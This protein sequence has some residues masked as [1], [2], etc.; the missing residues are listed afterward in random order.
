VYIHVPF[1]RRRCDYCAFATWTDRAHLMG[2][3]VDACL[4]E[5][6]EL[7]TPPWQGSDGRVR[8]VESI[9]FGGGTPSLLPLDHLSA[10]VAKVAN[11][12][13]AEVTVE[14]NPET[15]TEALLSGYQRAGVT[16]ISLGVQSMVPEVLVSLGRQHAPDCVQRAAA[17]AGRLGFR[18]GY[19]VDLIYGAAGETLDQWRRSLDAVLELD[20]APEH[21]SAYAL[22]VEAGTP[23]SR[24]Q[25]RYPDDDDQ[26]DKYEIAEARLCD[27][28]YSWYELSNWAKP[29]RR[30]RHNLLYWTQGDY[31]GIGCAAHSH[32][33]G[34]RW[35]NVR[36]PERY[37]DLVRRGGEPMAAE[38]VL[39][40]DMAALEALQLSLRTAAGVPAAALPASLADD[41]LVHLEGDR[42][43]LSLRGRLLA[44]AVAVQLR[45]P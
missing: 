17:L 15:A 38:E 19:S 20:P 1:C 29:G 16:R 14:V 39:G 26:A 22:T 13:G 34:R 7:E 23:L 24:D 27:A 43:V 21:V 2:D 9:F 8:P 25:R 3:Y 35:W 28:G 36:T 45:A 5:M 6:E 37:I 40:E 12:P 11:K 30:C 32:S 44:N 18:D 33:A 41:G 42:A 4:L 10:L 31:A